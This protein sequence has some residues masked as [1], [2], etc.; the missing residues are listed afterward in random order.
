MLRA[1]VMK[2][3]G[4]WEDHL[5]LIEFSY[6]NVYHASI[7]MAPFEA[8]YGRKCKSPV[9]WNDISETT[10]LG[11]EMIEDMVKQVKL[12]QEKKKVNQDRLKSYADLKRKDEGYEVGEKVLLKIS[13]MKGVFLTRAIEVPFVF[14]KRGS[15]TKFQ[16]DEKCE[17]SFQE[18]KRRLIS[19]PIL[20]LPSGSEGFE[21]YSDASK[22]GLGCVLM[23][24][25]KVVAYASRQLKQHEQNYPTHDLELGEVVFAL[26]IWRHYLYGVRFKTTIYDEIREKQMSDE[27]LTKVRKM[28]EGATTEFDIN[29]SGTVKYKRKWCIPKDEDLK[30]KILE[31]AHNI[32]YSKVKIQH[33]RPGGKLQSLD[34]PGWKWEFISLDFVM[35][36][37]LTRAAKN[38]I[39]VMVDRL[40]KIARFIAIKDTW[41]VNQLADAYVKEIMRLHGVAKDIISDRDPRF[42]S[43]FWE[44]LQQAFGT[45]LKF[46]TTFHPVTDGQTERTIPTLEGMLRACVMD[47]GRSWDERLSIIEFSYNN[48]YHASI[49]MTPYEEL[50]GRKYRS[51][52][53]W[54]DIS[55][56]LTLGP[57]MIKET[58]KQVRLIQANM[59]ADQD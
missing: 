7:E 38:V 12:I 59:K 48:S 13:P 31:E 52:L 43:K 53:C 35:G 47:F 21:V 2:Y 39:W 26:K 16:W 28:K 32:L 50:Y 42:L 30:R 14:A 46:S 57:E 3:Q 11:L 20:T 49:G 41:N 37:P 15:S 29:D 10:V 23:Q 6:N 58:T 54:S 45:I 36:L 1:C 9:C 5:D 44:I 22:N 34:V 40:K 55:E 51:P 24:H 27:W 25:G 56:S 19:A 33:M 18:L 8:L 4:S 17:Q